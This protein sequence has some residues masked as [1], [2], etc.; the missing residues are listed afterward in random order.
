[1]LRKHRL[2]ARILSFLLAFILVLQDG[3]VMAVRA[4]EKSTGTVNTVQENTDT[5]GK[6]SGKKDAGASEKDSKKEDTGTQ[7]GD[8]T[9]TP[10]TKK[11]TD[12]GNADNKGGGTDAS[13]S[14]ADTGKDK[15]SADGK[16]DTEAGKEG[17]GGKTDAETGKEGVDTETD[18]GSDKEETGT[19]TDG[20]EGTDAGTDVS[21]N[22][23]PGDVSGNDPVLREPENYYP[24][25][26]EEDYGELAAYDAY[27]RTYL[28]GEAPAAAGEEAGRGS[29]VTVI[30]PSASYYMPWTGYFLSLR[31][32][33]I[34]RAI[35]T[36]RRGGCAPTGNR[37][38][39]GRTPQTGKTGRQSAMNT[40]AVT[41]SRPSSTRTA[42]G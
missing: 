12:A 3:A 20:A 16:T 8:S 36:T 6:D 35:P 1:M 28:T 10:D 41:S 7:K 26:D 33:A 24:E 29:Y 38:R 5:A 25:G 27:S 18:S 40:T 13:G 9:E 34:K 37:Q 31:R 4:D 14:A 32:K 30:G 42:Q 2:R 21:G 39:R 11:D 22:D 19:E 15:D 17:A 23:I